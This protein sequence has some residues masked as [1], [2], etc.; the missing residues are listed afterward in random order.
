MM[1]LIVN[2]PEPMVK[3]RVMTAKDYSNEALKTLHRA[4]V[5]HVEE[6]EELKPIDR[7]A[8]EVQRAGVSKLLTGIDDVLT[9]IP[10]GEKV[11]LR[12]DIEVIYTRPFDEIDSEVS[13]LCTKLGN[14]HQRA[15]KL[16]EE[17]EE[18]AELSRYLGPLEQQPN[19]RVKDLSFSGTY[20][21]S[22]IFVLPSEVYE[23]LR[24]KLKNYLF[25]DSVAA[26]ENETIF[27]VIAR[28]EDQN[29]IES[30]VKDGGGK[31][32]RIPDEDLTLREFLEAADGKIHSSQEEL[33]R[34]HAEIED[35]TRENLEKLVLF[36]E[37][38][39]AENER[40]AVLEKACE[41][42]YVRLI[43]GWIPDSSAE[44]TVSEVKENIG[45]V[46]VDT[47]KPEQAEE[48]PTKMRNVTA[49]KP[50]QVVVNL[51][52]TP[53]YREW[54][55]TP[56]I[57]YSFAFFFGLM[58]G[59][60]VYAALIMLFANRGLRKFVDDP[61]SEGFKLF[62]RTL[63]ISSGVAIVIGVLTGT[64]LGNFYQF[65]GIESL[66]LAKA[67]QEM[68]L[69]PML[70]IGVS[71]M[72]GLVHVN[73]AHVLALIRGVKEGQ[74]PVVINKAGLFI[75]QIGAIPWI[76][77]TILNVDIPLLTAQIY[78]ILLYIMILGIILIIASSF[79]QR[80]TFL[81]GIFWLFDLTG[82]LGDV[83]SY[84]RLAG[85]GLATYYLAY[86]F[87]LMATLLSHMMP[88][89]LV[90]V[91]AGSLI[92]VIVLLV[93]HMLNLAL[94][95]IT[96]FVHSLRLCFV[97]FLFKFYEGGGRGYSP[98]R[99]RTRPVFVKG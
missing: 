53:K 39:S 45:Y 3:L 98:F 49:L 93:G 85:V 30:I 47:R 72:I 96:C 84:A 76:L 97:E 23:P 7:E 20:L 31:V 32:Q 9:Y 19:I 11:S 10:K 38:L 95:G 50:F 80:G 24:D 74:K 91:I 79:M 58:L 56:I 70:F 15:A 69:A 13:L 2:T 75:L 59:D 26:I 88:A 77:H 65:F 73:I 29:I 68:Y 60:V 40:L 67:I 82:L 1:P 4:G 35:K 25:G 51:F 12:G 55:P 21:F 48:P 16:S 6:S 43:E 52:A 36:R 90:Q 78:S 54:D 66:A 18:L 94:S 92:F 81:G 46:F 41:A 5:L 33:T 34:L 62:Q 57:A 83:M 99:L 71:L 42:K 44:A 64:Y 28:V 17:I 87:N 86:C 61:E 8:L 89:G 14:M 27:Y 37:A 63:Y 22:R